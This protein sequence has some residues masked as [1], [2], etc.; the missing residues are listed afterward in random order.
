MKKLII[1]TLTP[2]LLI[3]LSGCWDKE[4]TK[5]ASP[6]CAYLAKET[7]PAKKNAYVKDCPRS[8]PGFKK[9][10]GQKW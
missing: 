1:S 2:L 8:G 10:S 9:S 4:N 7:D 6:D 3:S 5:V